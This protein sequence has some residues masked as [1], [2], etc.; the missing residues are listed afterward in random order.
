MCIMKWPEIFHTG[1][2]THLWGCVVQEV[3]P[4]SLMALPFRA[5][6]AGTTSCCRTKSQRVCPILQDFQQQTTTFNLEWE[7]RRGMST[8]G[9]GLDPRLNSGSIY[10]RGWQGQGLGRRG[11]HSTHLWSLLG[12]VVWNIA[13]SWAEEEEPPSPGGRGVRFPWITSFDCT[14]FVTGSAVLLCSVARDMCVCAVRWLYIHIYVHLIRGRKHMQRLWCHGSAPL[15]PEVL[16]STGWEFGTGTGTRAHCDCPTVRIEV[17]SLWLWCS[18]VI[19]V[20]RFSYYSTRDL[21]VFRGNRSP[22]Q[23]GQ[24]HWTRVKQRKIKVFRLKLLSQK[25]LQSNWVYLCSWYIDSALLL[26]KCYRR[27]CHPDHGCH[28]AWY[29]MCI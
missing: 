15:L 16:R 1:T 29:F 5:R 19:R 18:K 13:Y 27:S 22:P 8:G 11:D 17:F 2:T 12:A 7:S 10:W 28:F 21:P 4:S 9:Q 26:H 25:I 6:F 14:T 20:S 24:L 23:G 3:V